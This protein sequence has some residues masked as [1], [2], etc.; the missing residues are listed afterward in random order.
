M[1]KVSQTGSCWGLWARSLPAVAG[2]VQPVRMLQ[3]ISG[4]NEEAAD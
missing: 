1:G 3:T 2:P 4:S